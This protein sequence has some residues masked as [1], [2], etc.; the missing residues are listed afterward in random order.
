M[1]TLTISWADAA[2]L[3]REILLKD[4]QEEEVAIAVEYYGNVQFND[5]EAENVSAELYSSESGGS[6][7]LTVRT[8]L[9]EE[10]E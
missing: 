8:S 7:Y 1:K 2:K 4:P 9:S 5:G 3:L 10:E 6:N